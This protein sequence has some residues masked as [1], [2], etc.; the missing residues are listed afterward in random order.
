MTGKILQTLQPREMEYGPQ[1]SSG[2]ETG[3][4]EL[5]HWR[6]AW[7][8]NRV[9]WLYFDHSEASVNLL[10]EQALLE[11]GEIL[12][13]SF[14]DAP[15]GLVLRSTK[16]S[17]FCLGA[18]IREFSRLAE[19]ADIVEKLQAAH[20]VADRLAALPFPTLA[21][22]HG[23]CLGGGLELA[24]C[25]DYRLA[26]PGARMGLPEIL[27]GLHPGL[28]GTDRLTRLIDPLQAMTLML[29]GRTV[30]AAEAL[31]RGLVDGVVEE[32]HIRNAVLSVMQG[33][34]AGRGSG[35]KTRLL[36]TRPARRLQAR[37]M[38]GKSAAKA[39]PEYYPGP[40]A[41]I[42]LWENYG[43]DGEEMRQAEILSFARLMTGT[44]AQNLIRIFFLREKMK[45]LTQTRQFPLRHVHVIGAGAMGGEIAAWC[46]YKGL[47]V[48]LYD[49]KP[50]MIALAVTN[51]AELCRKKHLSA[52]ATREVLDRLIPDL[53]NHGLL[54]ADLVIEAVPEKVEIKQQL[55][56]EIEPL[57]KDGAVI[58]TN[59]SGIPLQQLRG[60]LVDSSR[61]V[62]LHFF[63]PVS[64]MELVEIVLHEGV[65]PAVLDKVCS[66]VGQIDRLPTL[67]ASAPGFLVN[68]AL[69]PYL[70]E[71]MVLI[72][73]G[74]PAETIDRAA[75]SFGMPV[76]PIELA[77]RVGLDICLSVADLLRDHLGPALAPIPQWFRDMVA[78]GELGHKTERGFYNWKNGQ[79]Q[80]DTDVPPADREILDRLLLPMLN[81]C[82]ACLREGIVNDED[83]LDGAMIFGTGF[84]PFRGGPMHYARN[85]GFGEIASTLEMLTAKH[86][87]RFRP[88]P[89]W[90][91]QD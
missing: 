72:D 57:L 82:M 33:K 91:E 23:L 38:R 77:D 61:L 27:L 21:I 14:R 40:E 9:A 30:T 87:E 53:R 49:R 10:S 84:A 78:A 13:T 59:T 71:A 44:T 76:G 55:Y 79:P 48:S 56:H 25:C 41:L 1:Q 73:E 39:P 20:A 52:A 75:L 69:T 83:L 90:R 32:R 7:D 12:E 15:K 26:V 31:K 86:G 36:T 54:R 89:G 43:G 70:M 62:G 4:R 80:K 2:P 51:T 47:R 29:T 58:A 85:R 65:D 68:R 11:L 19:E 88:D 45:K 50:E 35:L 8:E 17:G 81:A 42:A 22:I 67:V 66:F 3:D 6:L 5:N 64:K 37:L 63:N 74:V 16:E 28:G 60:L 18:D 34:L 24:L 46:A